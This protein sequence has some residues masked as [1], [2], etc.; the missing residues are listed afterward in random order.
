MS[1]LSHPRIVVLGGGPAGDVAALR[2]SI[3][4]AEVTLIERDNLGGTCM[5]WGCIP[6][7]SLLATTDLLRRI[8]HAGELGINVSG[9]EVDFSRM[10]ARKD[11][12]VS[13]MRRGVEA[14]CKR[15]NVT[16][17]KG[18]GVIEGDAVRVGKERFEFDHLIVC[19]GTAAGGLPAID[20]NHSA[21][22]TSDGILRLEKLP[23]SLVVI[24]G[25]V[26]GCEFA[27]F[28]APLGVKIDVVEVLPQILAGVDERIVRDFRRLMEKDGITFHTGTSV[29]DVQY[30]KNGVAVEL[31]GGER[32]R[33]EL[34]LVSV[35]RVPQTR[36][37]GLERAGVELDKRG[38]IV[39]DDFLRTKN[40]KIW[41]AGDCIGGLQLAHLASAEA[42]RAV[43]NALGIEIRAMDRT[44]VPSCIYTHPEIAM[45]GL[46]PQT[47][48][49]AGREVKTGQ[50]RFLGDGKAL[51]EGETDGMAQIYSDK[52]SGLILGATVMGIHAVEII[53]E[54]AVA[55]SDGLT[56]DELSDIIHA[57]PTVSEMV[58]DAAEQA[59]GLAP[60]LS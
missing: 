33:A 6:T 9:V 50:A 21:V 54:V 2:G 48:K 29:K 14:A 60:Y 8:H 56:V 30:A 18:S 36:E 1:A 49:D 44:V 47:A 58:K 52:E 5:N 35:G 38:N 37:I 3:R 22:V 13:T 25:G 39:V 34:M 4:G 23:Q 45:V 55:M 15:R 11:E 12:V 10:M 31:A 32:I 46:N 59:I 24:G 19:T 40:P 20:M 42:A 17:V 57:H 51:A 43:D 28:F 26:I 16:V 53:H 41:A 7:K 27:S